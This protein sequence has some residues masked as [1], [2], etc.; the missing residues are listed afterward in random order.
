MI[1]WELQQYK[2]LSEIVLK[3]LWDIIV[4][5]GTALS[6][7]IALQIPGI[8]VCEIVIKHFN[9]VVYVLIFMVA[10]DPWLL[11]ALILFC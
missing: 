7:V 9:E 3:Y 4:Y 8:E 11:V 5:N 2:W 6:S 1:K 10:I